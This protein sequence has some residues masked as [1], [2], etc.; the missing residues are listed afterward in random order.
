MIILLTKTVRTSNSF[1]IILWYFGKVWHKS[2]VCIKW[3]DWL[4]DFY[5]FTP[6]SLN[7]SFLIV[8]NNCAKE[9]IIDVVCFPQTQL[10]QITV[11]RHPFG[12]F[13]LTPLTF[14]PCT[15]T[16]ETF[17]FTYHYLAVYIP[18]RQPLNCSPIW[19]VDNF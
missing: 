18:I 5:L 11:Q 6:L 15:S 19:A 14:G 13:A 1:K 3:F 7:A 12:Y 2:N 17:Y 9:E 4:I 10:Q 16:P 8:K